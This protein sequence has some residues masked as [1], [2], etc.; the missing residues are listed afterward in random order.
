MNSHVNLFFVLVSDIKKKG[1]WF[2]VLWVGP[3]QKLKKRPQENRWFILVLVVLVVVC[4]ILLNPIWIGGNPCD[5]CSTITHFTDN[6]SDSDLDIINEYG[7]TNVSLKLSNQAIMMQWICF[8][9]IK[10]YIYYVANWF[11]SVRWYA[12]LVLVTIIWK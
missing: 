10:K 11:W 8:S 9:S 6:A 2:L 7:A 4:H 1:I 3:N 5:N 12:K